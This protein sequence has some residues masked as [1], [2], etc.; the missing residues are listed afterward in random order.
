M[1]QEAR[2]V[3]LVV[4]DRNACFWGSAMDEDT[5]LT[6]IAACSEDPSKWDDIAAC[7]PRYRTPV[8]AEFADSIAFTS[9]DLATAESALREHDS[10]VAIDLLQKRILTGRAFL[11][12]ERHSVFSMINDENDNQRWCLSIHLPPWW[13]LQSQ[14]DADAVE[15][16]RETP[17]V[18][19]Q[20]DRELLYG[21]VFIDDLANRILNVVGSKSWRTSGAAR[22]NRRRYAFTVQVHRDWLMTPRSELGGR[23]PRELLHGG[24][25]WI[26]QLIRGQE[27]RFAD[28]KELVALPT[29][30][31][32][33]EY[34]PMGR[35]EMV[36]YFDLCRELIRKGWEWCAAHATDSRTARR[37]VERKRELVTH[38]GESK[39]R[40]LSSPFDDGAPP[41]FMIECDRRRVP[42][43]ADVPIVGMDERP[44]REHIVDCDCPICLMMAEG[45]FGVSFSFT[46]GHH[47]ELDDEFA[48]SM[49]ETREEWQS[50]RI[51]Y[52]EYPTETD[53]GR[54]A[55]GVSRAAEPDPFAS[56]WSGNLS[57]EPLPGDP[58]GHLKLAFLLT[59]IVGELQ[60]A[61]APKDDIKQLNACFAAYRRDI[62][63]PLASAQELGNC[64]EQIAH[65]Y[66]QLTSRAADFQSRIAEFCRN[67]AT[68]NH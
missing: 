62:L 8:V 63:D 37:Q 16:E 29:S 10:W 21:P 67:T 31:S 35:E 41:R 66:P 50:E 5:A 24:L 61:G 33:F 19:R 64:L 23:T 57:D 17:L 48:F 45:Q 2:P 58:H 65:R 59:E 42:R 18:V 55:S 11:P 34:A 14:V 22:D 68:S 1:N 25:D 56:A 12:F 46:D 43:G 36:T 7:W 51:P 20:T 54:A 26:E 6:L 32:G 44:P 49:C 3:D 47:L 53:Q 39:E 30:F 28:S 40:W 52:V 38:L 13:E 60:L 27:I 9:V 15:R 4:I